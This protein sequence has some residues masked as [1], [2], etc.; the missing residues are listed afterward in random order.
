MA[1]DKAGKPASHELQARL[2]LANAAELGNDEAARAAQKRLDAAAEHTTT[3]DPR[4][5]APQGR[6]APDKQTS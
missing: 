4:K 2:E 1:E 6:R 5:R 3:S